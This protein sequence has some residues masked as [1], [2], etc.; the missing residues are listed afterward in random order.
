MAQQDAIIVGSG[1]NGLAAAIRLAQE[2]LSVTVLE[3]AD[4]IGGGTRSTE[5]MQPG[6]LHDVCSA[7]HPMAFTSPFLS[8]LPLKKHGLEWIQ[9]DVP[10]AHPLDNEPAVLLHREIERMAEEIHSDAESWEQLMNPLTRN[11]AGLSRDLLAPLKIPSH[12]WL[13]ARFGLNALQPAERLSQRTFTGHRAAALFAGLAGHSILPLE[14]AGTSA[15]GLVLGAAA[16]TVGWPLP[17]GGSRQIAHSMASLLE[18]FDGRIRTGTRI[19]SVHELPAAKAVL[20]DLTPAQLIDIL[21]DTMTIPYRRKLE[22]FRYGSGVFKVDY[23]LSEPVPWQDPRCLQ[24]GTV[25]LGGRLEEITDAE[26]TVAR[27]RH[28]ERP[29]VLV[30]QQSLFDSGRTPDRRETLW[31]YCHVPSGSTRDMASAIEAQ[32]E[33][34]APGFREVIE[35]RHIMGPVQFQEYNPNY[36]GGDINGGRQDLWQQFAR[37]AS[38]FRPYATSTDGIYLCSASTPPGGGV[39]GMCGFHAAELALRKTFGLNRSDWQF[40]L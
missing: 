14:Q 24:A 6:C 34:F 39:H 7:I 28:A 33:R 20:F 37:P 26:R 13:M 9:P 32:I 19:T 12:P 2:G 29:Y 17:K 23:L 4:E 21:G 30:A 31:A 5:L 15:I 25:H 18:E 3:A 22:K 11:W 35:D 40:R 8:S 38:L 1:P 16:H 27:G 36:I 10:M